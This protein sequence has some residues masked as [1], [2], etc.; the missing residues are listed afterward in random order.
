MAT[1]AFT[2]LDIRLRLQWGVEVTR[3][4]VLQ[5]LVLLIPHDL[6]KMQ[7]EAR[8]QA[9]IADWASKTEYA[10]TADI[11]G[12]A[13]L[14][15]EVEVYSSSC[16]VQPVWTSFVAFTHGVAQL[17]IQLPAAACQAKP[18]PQLQLAHSPG[19][20]GEQERS[21]AVAASLPH[22]SLL[23]QESGNS[24]AC[25]MSPDTMHSLLQAAALSL[26]CR[27]AFPPELHPVCQADL[28]QPAAANMDRLDCTQGDSCNIK[29]RQHQQQSVWQMALLPLALFAA[30]CVAWTQM[31]RRSRHSCA[32]QDEL[33]PLPAA[34]HQ[35]GRTGQRVDIGTSPLV[36]SMQYSS[37]QAVPTSG[38]SPK[39][40]LRQL[41]VAAAR[42]PT[43][44]Q[45]SSWVAITEKWQRTEAGRLVKAQ[46]GN[47]SHASAEP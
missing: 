19:I 20:G 32:M 43:S 17:N 18:C 4:Q 37:T 38:A 11:P 30:A 29:A 23:L 21:A 15:G 31:C 2:H 41:L 8:L 45:Q 44:R 7:I 47:P 25:W 3:E 42:S 46:S 5:C 26:T 35:N 34:F 40:E 28:R 16:S 6:C 24:E 14:L 22:G 1:Q 9:G 27:Q 33:G 13:Q 39:R 10:L 36:L 12:S